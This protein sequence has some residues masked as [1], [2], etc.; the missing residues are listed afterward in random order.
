MHGADLGHHPAHGL[1][2]GVVVAEL[3]VAAHE[4]LPLEN[5]HAA[6]LVGLD[7]STETDRVFTFS[8]SR[9]AGQGE[10]DVLT[11]Q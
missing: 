2:R 9:S 11:A 10:G 1:Q 3:C 7:K 5:D 4:V 6:A 8:V